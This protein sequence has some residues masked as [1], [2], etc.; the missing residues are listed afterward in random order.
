MKKGIWIRE[1]P[2]A[3]STF[4]SWLHWLLMN[5]GLRT[6]PLSLRGSTNRRESWKGGGNDCF[7]LAT[8]SVLTCGFSLMST[9]VAEEEKWGMKVVSL[10]SVLSSARGGCMQLG[11]CEG[12]GKQQAGATSRM[13][14]LERLCS[15]PHLRH[16]TI[17]FGWREAGCRSWPSSGLQQCF[18]QRAGAALRSGLT[19]RPVSQRHGVECRQARSWCSC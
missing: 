4:S 6:S 2:Q 5:A 7:I 10:Y 19:G 14:V 17:S 9:P 11:F 16:I 15:L 13:D 3:K 1:R 18:L 12:S 8:H